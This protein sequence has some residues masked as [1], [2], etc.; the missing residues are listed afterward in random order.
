M[1]IVQCWTLHSPSC[2]ARRKQEAKGPRTYFQPIRGG[3]AVD[4]N[5]NVISISHK[6]SMYTSKEN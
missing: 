3:R 5:S 1:L 6:I 2:E 4:G